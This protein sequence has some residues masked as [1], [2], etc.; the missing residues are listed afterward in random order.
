MRC[1]VLSVFFI[2]AAWT[3]RAQELNFTVRVNV[4]KLQTADPRI[5]ES[6]EQAM[7]EF[8]NNTKWTEDVFE[9]NERIQCNLLL[10]LQEELSPTSFKAD[11][12]IQASRPVF[13]STY[14]TAILNHIDREVTFTYEQYQPL[15]FSRNA[16]NNNLSSVLSFYAYII[17]G[18]DYDSFS[19][20]GGEPYFLIAQDIINTVPQ[21]V[22]NSSPG[23]RSVDGNRNRFWMAENLLSPRVRPLREAMY[24]YHRLAL[25]IMYNDVA[26]GRVIMA[27]ALEN[28]LKVNQTYPNSMAIQMF[29]NTKSQ[30]VMEIF[31]LGTPKEKEQVV[32][33][34]SRIDATNASRYRALN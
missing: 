17:L 10:T 5:F 25:D 32:R 24:T 29:I 1:V 22:A 27:E 3:V 19:L 31:K 8:L 16:F 2:L 6:L 34:M 9:T 23:W 7:A 28:V 30:E 18:L 4:Q 26:K 20:Y 21:S 14:E 33:V 12:A 11:I 13:G 15:I